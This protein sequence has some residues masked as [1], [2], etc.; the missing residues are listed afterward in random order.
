MN[1][2]I[3]IAGAIFA[4]VLAAFIV[5][6]PW[7]SAEEFVIPPAEPLSIVEAVP[8]P[9]P[10][11][12]PVPAPTPTP[13]PTPS[14]TPLPDPIGDFILTLTLQ[15]K[16]GQLFVARLPYPARA[17][18]LITDYHIGGFTFFAEHIS[19]AEQVRQNIAG[20]QAASAIPLFI[21]V[22][23]EGGRVSRIRNIFTQGREA[24]PYVIGS[25]GDPVRAYEIHYATGNA[26]V[27]LGFN[28][29]FAPVADIWTNPANTV[30]G[31]R[32]F[33]REPEI[34]AEMVEAAVR[35]LRS[36]GILSVI[37]H[38]PGHGDTVE[39]SH[40]Q[41]AFFHHDR[42]RFEAVES[43][44]FRRGIAAGADGVMVGHIATPLIT[45]YAPSLLATFSDYFIKTILREEWGFGNGLI[46]TDAL[47]MRGLT[48]Y[49]SDDEII[50]NA[51]L[52]GADI[53]LMPTV[54][55]QAV[56]ALINAYKDGTIEAETFHRRLDESLRRIL[57]KKE[58]L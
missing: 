10:S 15:E 17:Q 4:A 38:F 55:E 37:K 41:M 47:D 50:I 1:R 2:G 32:A 19:T 8:S 56:T 51:F 36:A 43:I 26:L 20:L 7:D 25:L 42:A 33:G 12:V 24:T 45:P 27:D 11:P 14:P 13:A 52:A 58:N 54:P 35:G 21:S 9:S 57:A 53:L 40:Y 49:Y 5:I 6:R 48:G 29:N 31:E 22:D 18:R 34:V 44:P 3:I 16:V 28:M 23:E 30:I 39:D 46:I